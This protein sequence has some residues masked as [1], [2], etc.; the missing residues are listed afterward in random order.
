M[1]KIGVI[2]TGYFGE[3]HIKILLQLKK[4]FNVIGF[5]EINKH[6]AK[7]IAK[8]Y[9]LKQ[10]SLN[11][12]IGKADIVNIT[13]ETKSHFE[14]IKLVLKHKKHL[15]V[16][17]PL[18]ET[19]KQIEEIK[20]LHKISQTHVQIGFI[21]RFNPAFLSF[22]SMGFKPKN[23]QATR[24]TLLSKRNA[25]HSIVQD[26]MIH[27]IDII[28]EIFKSSPKKI[29]INNKTKNNISCEILFKNNCT[30]QIHAERSNSKKKLPK[31]EMTITNEKNECVT[32]D[33]L[34]Q[35]ISIKKNK[36]II[37]E[38]SKKNNQLEEEFKYLYECITNKQENKISI[39]KS[40]ECGII[41]EKIEKKIYE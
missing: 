32:L 21:E 39:G 33:S 29:R 3:I 17:K 7:E 27:D 41:A 14:L 13:S 4:L 31:R 24:S 37:F 9:Q 26:L 23:I 5:V 12:L 15:F 36:K 1:L 16:E 28:N 34:R 20:K 38:E 6:R 11:E 8:K 35:K 25:S 10:L 22:S 19:S 2:G 30:A 40:L 18:C